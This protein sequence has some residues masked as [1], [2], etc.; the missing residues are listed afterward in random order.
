MVKIPEWAHHGYIGTALM[1]FGLWL[2]IQTWSTNG[3]FHNLFPFQ[4]VFA[5]II[6]FAGLGLFASDFLEHWI[7][8]EKHTEDL[9]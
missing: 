7:T 8:K 5:W 3:E 2:E 4:D 1:S 9:K 6:A